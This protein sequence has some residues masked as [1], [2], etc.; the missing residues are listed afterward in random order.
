MM[1]SKGNS[2][3]LRP[4]P[5]RKME[6]EAQNL[7]EFKQ[8]KPREWLQETEPQIIPWH[9]TEVERSQKSMFS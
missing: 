3:A 2:K 9:S 1:E 4:R 6:S 5:D 7:E 8:A